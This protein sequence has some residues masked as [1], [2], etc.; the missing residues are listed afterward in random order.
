MKLLLDEDLSP[1]L[2][3]LLA[4]L[5]P[6]SRHVRDVCLT[7]QSDTLIWAHAAAHGF[8]IVSKDDDFHHL[9]F[10]KGP[11]PKVIALRIGNCTTG[12]IEKLLRSRHPDILR[13]SA[14]TDAGLLLLP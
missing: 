7:G 2:V 14:D 5:F 8:A 6:E 1:R 12:Q 3:G 11:P 13:F 10:L 9:S 4:D